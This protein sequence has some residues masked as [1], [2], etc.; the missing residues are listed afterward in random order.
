V[1][2]RRTGRAGGRR[3][4]ATTA[5][6]LI[7]HGSR[8]PG[9]NALLRRVARSLRQRLRGA[10]VLACFLEAAAPGLPAGIDRLV[11]RGARRILLVPYFLYLGGHVEHDLPQEAARAGRRHPGASIRLAP[12]LG[13]D[14]RLVAI[15]ADRIRGGRRAARWGR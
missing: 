1:S 7:G 5:Y 14:R 4:R 13:F 15:V 9:A 6:L 11:A 3:G 8:V 10:P 12:P 2:G